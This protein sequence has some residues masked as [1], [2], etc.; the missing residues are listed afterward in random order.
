MTCR[1]GR[2]G[3]QKGGIREPLTAAQAVQHHQ[4]ELILLSAVIR[5]SA[6][7]SANSCAHHCAE[8]TPIED[9]PSAGRPGKRQPLPC[10][11]PC[12][13]CLN[14]LERTAAYCAKAAAAQGDIYIGEGGLLGQLGGAV[15]S[16]ARLLL[17]A[18]HES[19]RL[20]VLPAGLVNKPAGS[21][22]LGLQ[23][24]LARTR[25]C[26]RINA[27]SWYQS[28]PCSRYSEVSARTPFG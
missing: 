23:C 21:Q 15:R 7:K 17:L 28:Q 22:L 8:L 2:S 4:A 18:R 24:S 3:K 20:R 19:T 9:P 25:L 26:F 13:G 14:A 16:Y 6:G 27:L 12:L 11:M 5:G 1:S 10:Q